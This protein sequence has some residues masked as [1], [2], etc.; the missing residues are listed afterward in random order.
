MQTNDLCYALIWLICH[1]SN[2]CWKTRMTFLTAVKSIKVIVWIISKSPGTSLIKQLCQVE[3]STLLFLSEFV[4]V[5]KININN[6]L[7]WKLE[8][9]SHRILSW[10]RKKLQHNW[11][12]H[13]KRTEKNKFLM[14]HLGKV[15]GKEVY[16]GR[17]THTHP[18]ISEEMFSLHQ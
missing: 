13:S 12:Y 3:F 9:G 5:R 7:S 15:T 10:R 16:S 1:C 14:M 6:P 11:L 4:W 17:N 2:F 8:G 18:H